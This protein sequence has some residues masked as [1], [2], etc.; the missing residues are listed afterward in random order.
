MSTQTAPPAND[1]DTEPAP[2]DATETSAGTGPATWTRV[3]RYLGT[4]IALGA[5]TYALLRWAF[6]G[7]LS[8]QEARILNR[9]RIVEELIRHVE[10]TVVATVLVLA[11]AI[12]LGIMLTR[13]WARRYRPVAL[14][15]ANAGQAIPS[16][17][18]FAMLAV[19]WGM[20]GFVPSII[21][22]VFY[23]ILPVLR[24]TMV[25]L[26][27]VDESVIDAA[28]GMGMGKWKVLR[29]VEIPLAVPVMAAG[30]RTALVIVVGTVALATF[31]DGGGL[32]DFI[33]NGLKLSNKKILYT[34]SILTAVLALAVDWVGGILEDVFRP[35]G[36]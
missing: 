6:A 22:L 32:G 13:P 18:V 2:D 9:N 16:I 10:L 28:R 30:V 23:S 7:E 19:I 34:G 14:G 5:I 26:E 1:P 12:P 4:P 29:K 3:A 24:N 8:S 35:K 36:L 21:A 27:Q 25:G 15:V 31:I 11:I 33:N 20:F 17:G